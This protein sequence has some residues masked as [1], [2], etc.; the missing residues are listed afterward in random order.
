MEHEPNRW[1]IYNLLPDLFKLS[2]C[3]GYSLRYLQLAP[4]ISLG[5]Q[6]EFHHQLRGLV[7]ILRLA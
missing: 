6:L 7:P 5:E 2:V 1:L 3:L 4:L